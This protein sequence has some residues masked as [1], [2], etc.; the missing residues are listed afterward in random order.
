MRGRA[1]TP[2]IIKK[3][4]E[5][6]R[7]T[8]FMHVSS[9][10]EFEQG[11]PILEQFRKAYPTW[12]IVLSFFSPSGYRIRKD[13]PLVD[14]VVY[15]PTDTRS[16]M[17]EFL[18]LLNPDLAIFVK[19]D[20]W[21]NLLRELHKR[22]I[23]C[24]LISALFRKKQLFFKPWGKWYRNLLFIFEKIYVQNEE[25]QQL[26]QGIGIDSTLSGDTRFDR[27]WDIAK[28]PKEI[29]EA[30]TLKIDPAS[31][32]LVAGST[33]Q[34]DETLLLNYFNENPNLKLIIAP[35][36]VDK[37][38]IEAITKKVQRPYMLYSKREEQKH[39]EY[40][41][42]IID[43]IGILSSLYAYADIT[44]IGGGF[45]A[46]IH[47][48]LEAAVYALPIIFGPNRVEKFI[49]AVDLCKCKS[50]F[51]IHNQKELNEQLDRMIEDEA[52]VEEASKKAQEYVRKK[53]GASKQIMAYLQEKID[54]NEDKLKG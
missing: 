50:A 38:H 53:L 54:E 35:H 46:G 42:L 34:D 17:Q 2:L 25:S 40:D 30:L 9:L 10:G 51:I 8:L 1:E 36:E 13:Y 28:E 48:T 33:W 26:L 39:Q 31:K 44:Y 32:V 24:Y 20:F 7:K 47:N 21:P 3:N 49:E 37:E 22:T 5:A 12:Q 18:D 16:K 52:Y 15:L 4:I 23:P 43:E 45:G 29:V 41:C 14:A 19:Y 11:R 6:N 27:V